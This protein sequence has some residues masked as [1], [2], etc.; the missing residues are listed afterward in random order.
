MDTKECRTCKRVLDESE[1]SVVR[2]SNEG[3]KFY[4]PDCKACMRK[5]PSNKP[6]KKNKVITS[7]EIT[8]PKIEKEKEK[9]IMPFTDNEVEALKIMINEFKNRSL[10]KVVENN[11]LIEILKNKTSRTKTIINLDTK[12]KENLK[13]F[14][15][16]NNINVSDSVNF[17]LSEYFK[18][19]RTTNE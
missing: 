18:L 8:M 9:I 12:L 15:G 11:D 4:R 6:I 14:S 13:D 17:I 1:F 19:W 3:K 7:H 10:D 16:K 2:T 5:T